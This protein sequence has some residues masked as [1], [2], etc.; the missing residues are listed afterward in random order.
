MAQKKHPDSASTQAGFDAPHDILM[1][2][3]I[4]IFTSTPQGRYLSV[5]RALARMHGYDTPTEMIEY[6]TDIASQV[7][8]DPED[9]KGFIRLLEEHGEVTNHESRFRH[10]NGTIFWVSRNARVVKDKDGLIF[11]YQG[12]TTDITDRKRAEE[13]AQNNEN[14]SH[15][16]LQTVPI[17]VFFKDRN[18]RYL[19]FN[20]AF[21]DFFGKCKEE[22]VGKS[23]FDINPPDLAAVYHAKDNELFENPDIQIYESQVKNVRGNVHDV[24]FHKASLTD[25]HGNISGLIGAV[26]DVTE[27]KRMEGALHKSKALLNAV[28]QM[29]NAGGWELDAEMQHVWWTEQVYRI[30]GLPLDYQPTV[31]EAL[32]YYHPDDRVK[33]AEALQHT[34]ETG[35][36][37]DE[38]Y[39]LINAQG[40]PLW[41][42]VI[43]QPL[44]EED[45]LKFKGTFQDITE[46]KQALEA[47][48]ESEE[49]FKALHNASFGGIAIHDKGLILECNQGLSEISGFGY[50][51]LIGM[52]GLL[53]IAEQSRELVMSNILSGHEK[54]YEVFGVRKNGEEYPLRLEARNIP[55]KGKMVRVV[56]FRDITE[57]KRAEDALQQAFA[58]SKKAALQRKSM[59]DAAR[60]VLERD[61]FPTTA[62]HIFD[63][64]SKTIGSTA[65]Y[66]ALLS[67]DGEENELLFLEAGGRPCSVNPDLPMPIRGLRAEA[68]KGNRV[69]YDNDF[70]HSRWM[71]FMPKGHVRLDNVLF[72]PLVVENV[73]QGIIGL[74]NKPGG[75]TDEDASIAEAFGDLA[76]IA[77]RNS[78]MLEELIQSEQNQKKAAVAAEAANQAKSEFLANMSHEIRTPING[79]MGMMQLL[80]TTALDGE[81]KKY[82]RLATGSANRLTKLLSDILDLSR[83]EAGMMT[84]DEAE[85]VVQ[86]L[87]DSVSDLFQITTRDKGIHL[88]CFIDP[89][90]P[91]RLIGDEARVRQILFNLTGNALKFTNKGSVKVEMTAMSS[92]R[93]S[94]CRIL[95]TVS[96]TG[97][98]IPEDKQDGLFK[99]FV[100]VDCSY[101]RSYQ[102]AGL[103]LAIV[104]RLV[105]LMGGRVSVASTLGKGTTVQ[106]LLP[107][108]LAEGVSI[109]SEQGPRRLTEAKQSL[110]ILL[111]EDEPSSSF[112]TTKLLEKAGHTLTLAENGQQALD[113]LAAQDFDVILMDVQMP[114]LNGVEATQEIRR[115]EDEKNSSIPASQ[116]SRIPIIALTAYAMLGDREKFL[117]A[118]MDD[119][120]GKPVR[121]E[122][123]AKVLERVV[124]TGKA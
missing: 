109:S 4:G 42:R 75:F 90:I 62:R 108:K 60:T 53:L 107:L 96:D 48:E 95:L 39:R 120:L 20:Q 89:D 12:F 35:E 100:Q 83:V 67:D 31:E 28:G 32:G 65:G 56:E 17:P 115:L 8:A 112:P 21:Q 3:P 124:S 54:P 27:R 117:E 102:G 1:D 58:D 72:A 29:V 57:R 97:I 46:R 103:G 52:D 104:K 93:P 23:V 81:Q 77:L 47:L 6:I 79:I 74:A 84:I 34:R 44:I 5:N 111:A 116:H 106:V 76:A 41:V 13:Q 122:D 14:F 68:Y 11:A 101:T 123:L 73:T 105:D 55:Y 30:H 80:E 22:L 91:S 88:E 94:E 2:A 26:L 119:Y 24:I 92:E 110:R 69:V 70:M 87:A 71:A 98:G 36:P 86:E 50:D 33:L 61:D 37:F 38:E 15:S 64:A 82:V 78:K 43:C 9:R 121:M 7:Y 59:F 113:L 51:E 99:P 118:G 19:G 45:I 25:E 63:S 114:V 85:F 16:L 66:V 40:E 10:K 49:R 18:G